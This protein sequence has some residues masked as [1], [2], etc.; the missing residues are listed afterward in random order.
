MVIRAM[1]PKAIDV[2]QAKVAMT[3]LDI[4]DKL[5]TV[6]MIQK[7]ITDAV[8]KVVMILM[9]ITDQAQKVGL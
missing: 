6:A 3:I 9:A 8:A 2:R 4:I 7:V 5:E 1:M